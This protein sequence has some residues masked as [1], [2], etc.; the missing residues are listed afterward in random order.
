MLFT[1]CGGKEQEPISLLILIKASLLIEYLDFIQ[2]R[3]TAVCCQ[4]KALHVSF[5]KKVP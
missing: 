5:Q 2:I 1:A 3:A 4:I